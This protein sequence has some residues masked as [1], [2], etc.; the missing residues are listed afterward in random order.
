MQIL[1]YDI[2]IKQNI[3]LVFLSTFIEEMDYDEVY[4][5]TNVENCTVY[6]GGIPNNISGNYILFF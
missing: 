4:K 3:S 6:V 1:I 2:L 5:G